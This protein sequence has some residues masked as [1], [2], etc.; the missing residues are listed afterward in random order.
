MPS[1]THCLYSKHRSRRARGCL[2]GQIN[3]LAPLRDYRPSTLQF[4]PCAQFND[5]EGKP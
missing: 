4:A 5:F 3:H 1:R 2:K